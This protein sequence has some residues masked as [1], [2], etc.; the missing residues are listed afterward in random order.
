M[1]PVFLCKIQEMICSHLGP[2]PSYNKRDRMGGQESS[3][4]RSSFPEEGTRV[5]H[6][7]VMCSDG[8]NFVNFLGPEQLRMELGDP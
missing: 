4:T 2:L 3:L 6:P 5:G 8:V 1:S 7:L